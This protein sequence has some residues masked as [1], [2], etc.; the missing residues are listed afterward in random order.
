M[1]KPVKDCSYIS[2]IDYNEMNV[3]RVLFV[4]LDEEQMVKQM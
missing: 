2:Y 4:L 3:I 1:L